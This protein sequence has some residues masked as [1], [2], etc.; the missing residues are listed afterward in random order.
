MT[1]ADPFEHALEHDEEF[2]EVVGRWLFR[3]GWRCTRRG[4][5]QHTLFG[6]QRF[7]FEQAGAMQRSL[8]RYSEAVPEEG[9]S[10]FS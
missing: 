1:D 9:A 6:R 10:C 8:E 4:L 2:R 7:A 5:W 3:C